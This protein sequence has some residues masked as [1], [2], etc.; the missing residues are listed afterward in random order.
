MTDLPDDVLSF[1][2]D[3]SIWDRFFTVGRL[4]IVGTPNADGSQDLFAT[5]RGFPMGPA[6]LFAFLAAPEN[7]AVVNA[8]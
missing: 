7:A 6:N 3:Q 8:A 4:I 5:P 1:E 2:L